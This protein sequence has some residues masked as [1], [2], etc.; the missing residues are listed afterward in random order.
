MPRTLWR[1]SLSFGLVNVPVALVPA[2]RDLDVHFHQ[3]H[4]ETHARLEVRRVCTEEDKEIPYEEIG[5]AYDLDGKQVVL[6]DDELAAAQPEKTRTIDISEFV[7]SSDVDPVFFNNS[8]FLVPNEEGEGP[9]RAY[10]LLVE[11]MKGS[12]RAALGQFVLRT[13]EHLVAIRVR[14]D[15]L[16]LTTMIFADE[17]RP[18]EDVPLP[19]KEHAPSKKEL[20]NAVALIKEL[21][22]E[23]EPDRYEDRHRKRLEKLIAQKRKG[24]TVQA[25]AEPETPKAVPDLLAALEQSLADVRGTRDRSGGGRSGGRARAKAHS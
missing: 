14:D 21:S 20:D 8:Y 24:E 18:I 7:D 12:D 3:L 23:F 16:Q 4:A 19:E 10:R 15:L 1:G 17:V 25:P 9:A 13:R 22:A 5:S 11:A 2:V 6:T